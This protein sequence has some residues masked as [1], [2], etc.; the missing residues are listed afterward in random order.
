MREYR[1][2]MPK[3]RRLSQTLYH[4]GKAFLCLRNLTGGLQ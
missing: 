4:H 2:L 1:E 3:V